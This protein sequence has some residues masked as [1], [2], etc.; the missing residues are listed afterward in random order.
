Q[1]RYKGFRR[2]ILSTIRH[3]LTRDT[4]GDY[5]RLGAS[6]K[7]VLLV[8]GR[9]DQDVPFATSEA[10]RRDLP[11]AGFLPVDDAAH[12]PFYEHPEVVNPALLA[13]LRAH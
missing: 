12:V 10:V 6:G 11:Q 13:F 3:Y 1:M 4:R 5:R 8:W 2:A 7:P 9:K